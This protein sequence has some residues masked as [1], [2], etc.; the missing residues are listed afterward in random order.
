MKTISEISKI[1]NAVP[2]LRTICDDDI[3]T[4]GEH[5]YDPDR[6]EP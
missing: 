4:I 2:L 3:N 1:G 6:E 5:A